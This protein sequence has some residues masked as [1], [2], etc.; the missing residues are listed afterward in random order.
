MCVSTGAD[1]ISELAYE[2]GVVVV[3]LD[4]LSL[5]AGEDGRALD[6]VGPQRALSQEHLLRLQVHLP[7]HLIGHLHAPIIPKQEVRL[8]M[9]TDWTNKPGGAE[10]GDRRAEMEGRHGG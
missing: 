2:L 6:E 9:T 4:D 10:G 3:R 8:T 7:D 1:L 5:A